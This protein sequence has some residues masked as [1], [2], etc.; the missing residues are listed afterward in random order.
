LTRRFGLL[1][2]DDDGE[3]LPIPLEQTVKCVEIPGESAAHLS[4]FQA[5]GD[6]NLDHTPEGQ[7]A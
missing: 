6:R 7:L 5:V 1:P 3:V 2:V 4:F